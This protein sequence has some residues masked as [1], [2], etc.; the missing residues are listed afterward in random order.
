MYLHMMVVASSL[1]Y[2]LTGLDGWNQYECVKA[3]D[4]LCGHWSYYCHHCLELVDG[5]IFMRSS[6]VKWRHPPSPSTSHQ[7][8]TPGTR[9]G[10]Y[11]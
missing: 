11:I 7:A 4:V 5:K 1:Q 6:V 10:S 3:A 2:H 8:T 9:P